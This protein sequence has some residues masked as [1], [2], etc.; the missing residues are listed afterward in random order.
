MTRL[1]LKVALACV[2]MGG[3]VS[4]TAVPVQAQDRNAANRLSVS[5]RA[6]PEAARSAPDN[7]A[8][9]GGTITTTYS[10][11]NASSRQPNAEPGP[12]PLNA[13]R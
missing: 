10:T 13:Q 4:L 12:S 11:E 6:T 7:A 5:D 3:G 1:Q 2:A 8:R 9:V